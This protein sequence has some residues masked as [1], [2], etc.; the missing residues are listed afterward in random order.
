MKSL[1]CSM[2]HPIVHN[3]EDPRSSRVQ[4]WRQRALSRT[5]PDSNALMEGE[6]WPEVMFSYA[7]GNRPGDAEGTGPGLIHAARLALC[8]H[9]EGNVPPPAAL[10]PIYAYTPTRLMLATSIV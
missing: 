8:F 4:T 6:F 3:V 10:I 7:T 5:H 9:R 2:S 1:S